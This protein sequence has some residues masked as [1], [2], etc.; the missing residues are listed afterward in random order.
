MR[1]ENTH[2]CLLLYFDPQAAT[3]FDGSEGVL[4][5]VG[6]RLLALLRRAI[7]LVELV[8]DH[9]SRDLVE[10]V[11]LYDSFQKIADL[12]GVDEHG[13]LLFAESDHREVV[14]D[15][16]LDCKFFQHY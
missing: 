5:K 16:V 8:E 3:G 10:E 13:V 1:V 15:L 9:L 14:L 2:V 12:V 11:L 6:Y 4:E 7:D